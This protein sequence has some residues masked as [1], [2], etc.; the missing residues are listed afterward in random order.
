VLALALLAHGVLV[1]GMLATRVRV[2]QSVPV[3]SVEATILTLAPPLPP[4]RAPAL[5][6][7]HATR[8]RSLPQA[9]VVPHAIEA[10][11]LEPQA[12]AQAASAPGPA[13]S[14]PP[15]PLRLTLSR[16]RLR[17]LIAGTKPALAQSLARAPAPSALA[18]IGGD[19]SYSEKA[20]P[21]GETEVHVHGSCFKMVPT[22]V[23]QYDPFN[24]AGG[25]PAA[26]D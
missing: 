2:D 9:A 14:A 7:P 8:L 1:V 17:A 15:E 23:S 20:L 24:H 11:L 12:V 10:P 13:P 5:P 18:R 25:L 22:P 4:P 21:G 16:D 6:A 26:C 19:D 3:T